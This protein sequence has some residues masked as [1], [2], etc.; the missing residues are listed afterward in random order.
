MTE[1]DARTITGR[2]PKNDDN[3]SNDQVLGSS[4]ELLSEFNKNKLQ[5]KKNNPKLATGI[6]NNSE[7]VLE[8][9]LSQSKYSFI[10]QN[11]LPVERPSRFS[12]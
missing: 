11:D 3:F 4:A 8:S 2:T 9:T 1:I 6:P 12:R 7:K 10:E 5:P